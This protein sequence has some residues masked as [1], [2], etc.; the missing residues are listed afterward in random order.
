MTSRIIPS[1]LIEKDKNP[2][3]LNVLNS[4]ELDII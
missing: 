4:M 3:E 2:V 1:H